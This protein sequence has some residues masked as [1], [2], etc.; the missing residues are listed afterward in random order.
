MFDSVV[1]AVNLSCS[2][3]VK[4]IGHTIVHTTRLFS[5][6]LPNERL[7]WVTRCEVSRPV[8]DFS[9]KISRPAGPAKWTSRPPSPPA[10]SVRTTVG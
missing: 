4:S 2:W 3:R 8:N 9:S 1:I 7:T 5:R 10:P 6:A